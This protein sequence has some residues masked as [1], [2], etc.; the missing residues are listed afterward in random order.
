MAHEIPNAGPRE[1]RQFGLTTGAIVLVL[2]AGFF[3]WVL[4]RPIPL[5]TLVVGGVLIAWGLIAP[6]SLK[7]VYRGWMTFGLL[8]SKVTTPVLM[9]L[10]FIVVIFPAAL[11][12]RVLG[13]D[14]LRRKLDRAAA[15]YRVP[16]DGSGAERLDK[17]Y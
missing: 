14:P 8:M 13:K 1:L 17:P 16:S 3:P 10:I 7:P 9:T 12:L 4:E 5:W 2:F 11:I 6:A 15:T